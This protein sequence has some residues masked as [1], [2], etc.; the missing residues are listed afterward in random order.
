MLALAL[1]LTEQA[2]YDELWLRRERRLAGPLLA[3]ALAGGLGPRGLA[4]RLAAACGGEVL[5]ECVSAL[6]RGPAA[7][8]LEL[9]E[10]LSEAPD[11]GADVLER[12]LADKDPGVQA[13]TRLAL[14][15]SPPAHALPCA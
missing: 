12:L 5:T 8:R 7:V 10:R 15:S 2:G 6:A 3:R 13:A 11:V 1:E 9:A 14:P 4:V